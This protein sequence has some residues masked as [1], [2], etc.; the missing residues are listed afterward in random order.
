LKSQLRNSPLVLTSANPYTYA[1]RLNI[2]L[3][4]IVET[5]Q[6]RDSAAFAEFIDQ[7]MDPV[8]KSVGNKLKRGVVTQAEYESIV[9]A[10]MQHQEEPRFPEPP[11][12]VAVAVQA[13]PPL[14]PA[15]GTKSVAVPANRALKVE[16]SFRQSGG[17]PSGPTILMQSAGP[18]ICAA[19][20]VDYKIVEDETSRSEKVMLYLQKK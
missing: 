9:S 13:I 14:L 8:L 10:H 20:V 17:R 16:S 18:Q 1:H 5:Q 15:T 4:Q 6:L 11:P 19:E 3:K 7:T 12:P 2:L